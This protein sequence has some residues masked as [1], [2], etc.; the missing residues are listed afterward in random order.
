MSLQK[1][2]LARHKF[3]APLKFDKILQ[4]V[5]F[6]AHLSCRIEDIFY[7]LS[8]NNNKKKNGV[9][10]H[11]NHIEIQYNYIFSFRAIEFLVT[12]L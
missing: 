12:E 6:C 8:N 3:A 9:A 4:S 10:G 11:N 7:K 1:L 2:S 5:F